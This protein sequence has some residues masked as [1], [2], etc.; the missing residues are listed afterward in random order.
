M[1]DL[2]FVFTY[3]VD[4]ADSNENAIKEFV[5]IEGGA[6][7]TVTVSWIWPYYVD[8]AKDIADTALGIAHISGDVTATIT[9]EQVD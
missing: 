5:Q 7:T 8:A 6:T 3:K 4:G 2:P 9:A 1:D